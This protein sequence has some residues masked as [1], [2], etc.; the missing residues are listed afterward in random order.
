MHE[1]TCESQEHI[2]QQIQGRLLY[3]ALADLI[4]CLSAPVAP[5]SE[6]KMP[7]SFA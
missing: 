7:C 4:A 6:Q 2:L 1:A 3:R 5:V